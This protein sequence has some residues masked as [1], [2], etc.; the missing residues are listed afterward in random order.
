MK[1]EYSVQ[2]VWSN[3][4]GA[5]IAHVGELAGCMAD[6]QSPEEALQNVKVV[7]QEWIEVAK[8]EGRSIPTP[9]TL[10][11]LEKIHNSKQKELGEWI[12]QEVAKAV[13]H[14]LQQLLSRQ[15]QCGF[16]F[17][18]SLSSVELETAGGSRRH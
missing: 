16:N 7:A 15:P 17:R 18:G 14:I 2:I 4:D 6:G 11:D 10:Q 1:H 9:L 12:N 3:E 8:E 13:N 5:Y